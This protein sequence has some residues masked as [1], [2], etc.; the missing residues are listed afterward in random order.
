[1]QNVI[2]HLPSSDHGKKAKHKRP[3]ANDN[4]SILHRGDTVY[5]MGDQ[6]EGIFL[7]NAGAVKVYRTT[8]CGDQ[9]IVGFYMPGEVI[10]LDALSDGVSRSTAVALDT[11]NI[12][13]IPFSA[14]LS[15]DSEFGKV[16]FIR[17]IGTTLIRDNDLIMMLSQRTAD[18]RL[19]WFL[20]EFSDRLANRGLVPNEFT[21]PMSRTDIAVF[22]GLAV[23]TVCRELAHFCEHG[24]VRK[25]RRRLHLL[26]IDALRHIANGDDIEVAHPDK[27]AA[28]G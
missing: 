1:M 3:V 25:D 20:V 16:D 12:S 8:E 15:D 23:E 22:L 10:G 28:H 18:R 17:R 9:Q 24:L 2:R 4:V 26:D 6:L 11:T 14:M 27:T 5:H 19:A 7:V 13:L 21:L